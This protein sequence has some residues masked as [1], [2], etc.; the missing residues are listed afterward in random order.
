[1][2]WLSTTGDVLNATQQAAFERYVAAGKGYA[3]IH[4]AS[5]TE[6]DWAWYGDLVGA[7]F[8]NHPAEQNATVVGD[9][10]AHPSTSVIPERWTRFDEW[11]SYRTNPR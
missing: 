1:M 4:A 10:A 2:I 7:Y 11:Y 3:G 9:D 5:D 8:A 6:Y